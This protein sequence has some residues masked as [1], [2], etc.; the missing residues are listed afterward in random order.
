MLGAGKWKTLADAELKREK[1]SFKKSHLL[2][3]EVHRW[4]IE[5]NISFR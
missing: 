1:E 2:E 5:V 4:M 3:E